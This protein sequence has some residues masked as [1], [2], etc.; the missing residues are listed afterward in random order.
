MLKQFLQ[1]QAPTTSEYFWK[2]WVNSLSSYNP[3]I[4]E[5]APVT[6]SSQA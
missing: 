6:L 4:L 2:I 5:E 1:K 3:N